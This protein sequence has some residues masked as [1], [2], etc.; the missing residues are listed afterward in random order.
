MQDHGESANEDIAGILL[1]EGLAEAQKV[2]EAW[3]A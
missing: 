3:R 2:F 1:V